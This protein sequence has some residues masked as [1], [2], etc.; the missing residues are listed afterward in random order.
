MTEPLRWPEGQPD[1]T[2]AAIRVGQFL[3]EYGDDRIDYVDGKD[4]PMGILSLLFARD[5]QALVNAA[6]GQCVAQEDI[7]LAKARIGVHLE[8]RDEAWQKL[9]RVREFCEERAQFITAINNCHP[10]NTLDYYRWQ[11]GAEARRQLSERLGLPVAWPAEDKAAEVL[12][13]EDTG[14]LCNCGAEDAA[15]VQPF[16]GV[17]CAAI[18]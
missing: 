12:T 14:R 16:H 1:V 17:G 5:L 8:E 18:S 6:R 15:E 4:A 2:G 11:G 10:D 9:A 13:R 7:R 3:A